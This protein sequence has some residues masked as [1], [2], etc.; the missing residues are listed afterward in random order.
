MIDRDL[1][2]VINENLAAEIL[3]LSTRTLQAWRISGRGPNFL[4]MGR[5][6]RYRR[7]DLVQFQEDHVASSTSEVDVKRMK[8]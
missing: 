7:R 4:K 8:P 1:D 6:V 2:A 3:G 5:T